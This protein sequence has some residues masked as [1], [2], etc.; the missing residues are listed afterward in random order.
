VFVVGKLFSGVEVRLQLG[1][2]CR[3]AWLCIAKS[4][5][6]NLGLMSIREEEEKSGYR[7]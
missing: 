7:D 1:Y 2:T 6:S 4:S 5:P 3:Q